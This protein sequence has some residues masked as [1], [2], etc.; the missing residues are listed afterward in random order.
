MVDITN[1][2]TLLSLT[3]VT[4]IHIHIHA[5]GVNWLVLA[6]MKAQSEGQDGAA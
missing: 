6:P 5:H 2:S 1:S 3:C 4:H